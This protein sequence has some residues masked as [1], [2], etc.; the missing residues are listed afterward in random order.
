LKANETSGPEPPNQDAPSA[1]LEER[2]GKSRLKSY[3][4]AFVF[5]AGTTLLSWTLPFAVN[6]EP[7]NL[8]VKPLAYIFTHAPMR[9][10]DSSFKEFIRLLLCLVYFFGLWFVIIWGF[11][12]S[13]KEFKIAL[14]LC[15]IIGLGGFKGLKIYEDQIDWTSHGLNPDRPGFK[16]AVVVLAGTFDYERK[17]WVNGTGTHYSGS[18]RFEIRMRGSDYYYSDRWTG[19]SW[20]YGSWDALELSLPGFYGTQD[21][22]Y[23][24]S[25]HHGGGMSQDSSDELLVAQ[26]LWRRSEFVGASVADENSFQEI[27][28]RFSELKQFGKFQIP[29]RIEFTDREQ[30]RH[31]VFQIRRVEFLNQP[32]TNWF[33]MIKEKYFDHSDRAK[34]LWMT[35]LNEVGWSGEP[36][37]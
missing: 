10:I 17:R 9:P 19:P 35:N 18:G 15:A 26:R 28:E 33:L 36:R 1:H 34:Q 16:P 30:D 31:E 27:T 22:S 37:P 11:R 21:R 14:A 20:K 25:G 29:E 23:S 12:R 24:K 8:A 6:F 7:V 4:L 2:L 5:A 13:T 32:S 3:Q